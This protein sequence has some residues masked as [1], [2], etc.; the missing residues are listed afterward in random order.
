M[1]ARCA[2]SAGAAAPLFL[3]P[4]L[5]RRRREGRDLDLQRFHHLRAHR[6]RALARRAAP[7]DDIVAEAAVRIAFPVRAQASK[8]VP[9][10]VRCI[11]LAPRTRSSRRQLYEVRK[12]PGPAPRRMSPRPDRART[13]RGHPCPTAGLPRPRWAWPAH[14]RGWVPFDMGLIRTQLRGRLHRAASRSGTSACAKLSPNRG[15]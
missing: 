11:F 5:R 7:R 1:I 12:D 4:Q 2:K 3:G 13:R 9:V 6:R 8:I 15:G 10:R 14:G